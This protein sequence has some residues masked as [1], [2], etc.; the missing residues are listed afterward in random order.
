M[1]SKI[2]RTFSQAKSKNF[3]WT[4]V[5]EGVKT[6]EYAVRGIVPTTA[7]HMKE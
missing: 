7:T 6:A 1:I 5:N 3:F 2:F 4:E